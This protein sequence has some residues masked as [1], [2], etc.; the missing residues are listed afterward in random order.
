MAIKG[1]Y[2]FPGFKKAGSAALAAV[3]A[4]TTWGAW[5][6]KS[7]FKFVFDFASGFLSEWL[8]NKGLLIINIGAIYVEGEIDQSKFDSAFDK[9]LEQIKVPGLSD[10]Q[11]KGIDD[12]VIKAFRKFGR[13]TNHN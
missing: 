1:K 8:A 2:D 11:K 9:A 6:I 12:E 4:S 13:V 7:P 10:A 3:L 5:L